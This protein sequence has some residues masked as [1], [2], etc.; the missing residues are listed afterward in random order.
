VRDRGRATIDYLEG[1]LT[2][3]AQIHSTME[4]IEADSVNQRISIEFTEN[5]VEF[6]AG[7]RI[8]AAA[9]AKA[10]GASLSAVDVSGVMAA[11]GPI[12]KGAS[13]VTTLIVIGCIAL[14]CVT[15]A[16]LGGGSSS[17]Q[18]SLI[19]YTPVAQA[20]SAG[21]TPVG[22]APTEAPVCVTTTP[23]PRSSGGFSF[24]SSGGSIR[25]GGSSGHST[26]GGG[27]HSS[28]GGGK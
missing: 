5:E 12:A 1:E 15:V 3:K 9:T 25:S 14:M 6:Y 26:G 16:L 2:W 22:G 8:N 20:T 23:A 10:F 24:P 21:P 11:A 7:G 19:C 17:A 4:Y 27:G 18:S 28:G 13:I